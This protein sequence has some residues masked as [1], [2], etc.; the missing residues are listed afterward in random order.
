MNNN[1]LSQYRQYIFVKNTSFD[2]PIFSRVE[3]LIKKNE[4]K[5]FEVANTSYNEIS[6]L[7][8]KYRDDFAGYDNYIATNIM[9]KPMMKASEISS[10]KGEKMM[11]ELDSASGLFDM[12]YCL[13]AGKKFIIHTECREQLDFDMLPDLTEQYPIADYMNNIVQR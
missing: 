2:I 11:E 12:M 1:T 8:D 13:R 10:P 9:L 3:N 6:S 4:T 5:Y 7:I